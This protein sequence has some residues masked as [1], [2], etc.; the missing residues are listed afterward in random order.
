MKILGDFYDY[1]LQQVKKKS[2]IYQ[3]EK[4]LK[5]RTHKDKKQLLVRWLDIILILILRQHL[6]AYTMPNDFYVIFMFN[7]FNPFYRIQIK[8]VIFGQNSFPS[9]NSMTSMKL[10]LLTVFL[11]NT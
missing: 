9:S 8:Q 2:E 1:E 11:K 4:M 5:I 7:V 10:L 3:I 6:K